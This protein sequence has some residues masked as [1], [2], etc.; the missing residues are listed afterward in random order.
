MARLPLLLIAV[1]LTSACADEVEAPPD[2]S[3][4]IRFGVTNGVRANPTLT[5][6]LV[7][8]I[9][10]Q[11]YLT[12]EVTALGPKEGALTFGDVELTGVDLQPAGAQSPPWASPSMPPDEY[13]VLG[14]YDLDGNGSVEHRPD[15]GDPVTLPVTNKFTVSAGE[16]VEYSA[17]FDLVLN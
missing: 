13:V 10:G 6:P 3:A 7:G 2:G 8:T 14:F 15:V 4:T 1:I 16:P 11:V 17:V 12:S 5:D 9:Y